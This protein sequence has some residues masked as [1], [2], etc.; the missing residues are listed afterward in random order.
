MEKTAV[1]IEAHADKKAAYKMARIYDEIRKNNTS[2]DKEFIHALNVFFSR[3]L[4]CFFAED[5]E[6][7]AKGQFIGSISAHTQADGSDLHTYLDRL[8]ESFD[9][10]DKSEY[11]SYIQEFPYVNGGLFAKRFDSP[12]FTAQ[13]RRFIIECGELN[14]SQ[15]NPDIFGSMMQAVVG[16]GD[17]AGLGMHYTSVPNIMKVIEPL[18]LND[19]HEEFENSQTSVRKL[20]KLLMR[21]SEMKVFDPAC[22][23][24]NFLIIAYKELRKIEHQIIQKLI[25]LEPNRIAL[26]QQSE[27]KLENFYGIEIVDFAHEIAILLFG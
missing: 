12:S 8:F 25:E 27:I 14:W 3:L 20:E 17:R 6:V 2:T 22:G 7:F 1:A 18:F 15:I 10:E 21:I 19:L 4:F 16:Q 13:A 24:G 9:V 23:S 5:T 26:F 11:P